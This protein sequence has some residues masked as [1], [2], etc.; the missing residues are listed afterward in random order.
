[1]QHTALWLIF[2]GFAAIRGNGNAED[3]ASFGLTELEIVSD[4]MGEKVRGLGVFSH[5]NSAS[6]ISVNVVAPGLASN[7]N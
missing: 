7:F 2:V 6:G 5:S 1:M 3:L 4:K